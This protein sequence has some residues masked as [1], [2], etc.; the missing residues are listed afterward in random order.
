MA[1]STLSIEKSP[2]SSSSSRGRRWTGWRT[3]R[4][5]DEALSEEPVP[6]TNVILVRGTNV[7]HTHRQARQSMDSFTDFRIDY[8]AILRGSE[9]RDYEPLVASLTQVLIDH[10]VDAYY[11]MVD[12]QPYIL[13]VH[14]R[15]FNFLFDLTLA[16]YDK[17][18]PNRPDDRVVAA[19]GRSRRPEE[20]RD[21]SRIRGFGNIGDPS[22]GPM[23]KGHLAAHGMGGALDIN[24]FPQRREVNRGWSAE[25]RLYRKMERY[26]SEHPGTFMFSRPIYGDDSW[27]PHALEYGLLLPEPRFWVERFP[28]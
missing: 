16:K 28:N 9:V 24:I 4:G 27:T 13:D 15:G 18:D 6:R 23:D 20:K 19:Y 1:D 3:K 26:A 17:N 25:G 5:A 22:R 8:P 21:A 11:D 12:H 7:T 2:R 10:W 14:D